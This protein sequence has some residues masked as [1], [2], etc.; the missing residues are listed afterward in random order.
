MFA[1]S[2]ALEWFCAGDMLS[3]WPP[4]AAICKFQSKIRNIGVQGAYFE[5]WA[6]EY[7]IGCPSLKKLV[8]EPPKRNRGCQTHG[9]TREMACIVDR[10]VTGWKAI[11][12]TDD[13]ESLPVL[14]FPLFNQVESY[15][16]SKKH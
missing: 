15:L 2:G 13:D 14:Q 1:N 10:L 12:Q 3:A 11:L 4:L 16:R 6:Q 5:L 9:T 8:V 7:I